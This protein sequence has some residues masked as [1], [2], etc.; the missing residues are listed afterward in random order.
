MAWLVAREARTENTIMILNGLVVTMDG[1]YTVFEEGGVGG[2][3]A[4]LGENPL[5]VR[6]SS[7]TEI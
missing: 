3:S 7:I 5:A 1:I 6:C 2:L 4:T